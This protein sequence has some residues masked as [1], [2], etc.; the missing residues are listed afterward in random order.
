MGWVLGETGSTHRASSN[1]RDT[2]SSS[3]CLCVECHFLP[4]CHLLC[5]WHPRNETQFWNVTPLLECEEGK[6]TRSSFLCCHLS[7]S[8]ASH[9]NS[10]LLAQRQLSSPCSGSLLQH[11][12]KKNRTPHPKSPPGFLLSYQ[13]PYF[14]LGPFC[15]LLLFLPFSLL[16][17]FLPGGLVPRMLKLGNT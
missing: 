15:L 9:V 13:P 11:G 14:A 3:G 5:L 6:E 4:L 2:S 16:F 10:P 12:V 1:T 8:V 7:F 17:S